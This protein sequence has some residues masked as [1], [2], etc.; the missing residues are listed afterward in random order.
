MSDTALETPLPPA[1]AA[2]GP[3]RR[4]LHNRWMDF[5]TLGGG[6][7]VVMGAMAALYPRT[8]EAIIALAA[9]TL[10]LCHFVNHPHFAHSYQ[11]FYRGFT[12]KAFSPESGL[13]LRYQIAGIAV[14]ACIAVFF[15]VAIARG[16]AALLGLAAN[17]MFFT[18]GWHYAKQGYG[19]LMVDAVH[20][21]TRFDAG[22]R[23]RLLCN[24]HL[25]W[26]TYW[27]LYNN[28]FAAHDYWGLT[29]LMFDMPDSLL[30][31]M[32]A[33]LAVSTLLVGRDFF[34]KWRSERALPVN[35]LIAYVAATYIWL[36][37]GLIDPVL[38]LIV[39]FF[40]SLQYLSVVWRYQINVES[41]RHRR[42][43]ASGVRKTDWLRTVPAGLARFVLLGGLL[44]AVGF[45]WAPE[46]LDARSGHDRAVFGATAFL[47][48]GWTFINIHH[49]FLDTVI[50]R[51]ENPETR[52]HLFAPRRD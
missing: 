44:G 12:Y 22:A 15:A 2:K 14:P 48:M 24:T 31:A 5:L 7:L 46:F 36:P 6:S 16:S 52:R 3:S 11:L 8:E 43:P 13:R 9:A 42:R 26:V 29:Y 37:V 33:A 51:R 40:H 28:A 34:L 47:F 35:G 23:Q 30:A 21:D 17:V 20:N 32:L 25:T 38:P 18:V 19:I 45:W 49:Y 39:P 41:D 27:L 10:F 4:Y 1:T 50:W